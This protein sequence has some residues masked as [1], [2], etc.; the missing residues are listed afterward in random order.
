MK[1]GVILS[2]W[3]LTKL[4]E[5][6]KKS[7]IALLE[8]VNCFRNQRQKRLLLFLMLSVVIG[9]MFLTNTSTFGLYGFQADVKWGTTNMLLASLL[10]TYY[11][12]LP[13]IVIASMYDLTGKGICQ[14]MANTLSEYGVKTH[15]T[16]SGMILGRFYYL[17]IIVSLSFLVGLL[18]IAVSIFFRGA[19]LNSMQ[20]L[21]V[22]SIL[23]AV[24]LLGSTFFFLVTSIA[25]LAG[26]SRR[27]MI[28]NMV[29]L[30]FTIV[31]VTILSDIVLLYSYGPMPLPGT[32]KW[33]SYLVDTQKSIGLYIYLLSPTETLLTNATLLAGKI[34]LSLIDSLKVLSAIAAQSGAAFLIF[35]IVYYFKFKFTLRKSA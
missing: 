26:S 29:M 19:S 11:Y 31:V 16:Y 25:L 13:I 2:K 30:V 22:F 9:V 28:W 6:K 10:A 8:L 23:L 27:S 18:V 34:T 21:R 24:E 1:R 5:G 20:I 32:P 15:E 35:F 4:T 33:A 3:R 7:H 12:I 14:R 17:I